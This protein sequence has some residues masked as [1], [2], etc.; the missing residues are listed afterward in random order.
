MRSDI[1]LSTSCTRIERYFEKYLSK[2]NL[3]DNTILLECLNEAVKNKILVHFANRNDAKRCEYF[4]SRGGADAKLWYDVD[5]ED[6]TSAYKSLLVDMAEIDN[7]KIV[8]LLLQH[9]A[10]FRDLFIAR[11]LANYAV[12]VRDIG[13][14]ALYLELL[15]FR[16]PFINVRTDYKKNES[17]FDDVLKHDEK[18]KTL[19]AKNIKI[20]SDSEDSD[21]H[22]YNKRDFLKMIS[23]G[24][25]ISRLVKEQ[26][27]KNIAVYVLRNH[28]VARRL[29]AYSIIPNPYMR[30]STLERKEY[31]EWF[32]KRSARMSNG[33]LL[34]TGHDALLARLYDTKFSDLQIELVKK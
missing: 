9:G 12:P 32:K 23:N 26:G 1:T 29:F 24:D 14:F 19:I 22:V 3:K 18:L 5:Y 4:L 30:M 27:L 21:L 11:D 20:D 31:E 10:D 16:S 17:R 2:Q 33:S 34:T 8:L 7:N 13:C 6:G 25:L 28:S 15:K